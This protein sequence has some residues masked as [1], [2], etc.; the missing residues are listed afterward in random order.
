MDKIKKLIASGLGTGYLPVAPGTWGSASVAGIFLLVAWASSGKWA[1]VSGTMVVLAIVA[2]AACVA[3]GDFAEKTY[4]RKDPPQCT[5]DEWA[6]QAV[7]YLL[8]P[9]FLMANATEW[10]HWL[11]VAAVG[12]VVFRAAD[13]IKPPP[14]RAME[15]LKAGWGVLLDDVVAGVYANLVCQVLLRLWLIGI[16]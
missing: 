2:G 5:L 6:G 15:K 10:R 12:F 14:A 9:P 3:L 8:M 7:T 1:F 4:R 16:V 11:V 13:I